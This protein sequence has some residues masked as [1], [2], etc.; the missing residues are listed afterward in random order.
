MR[1]LPAL[2][3]GRESNT[4]LAMGHAVGVARDAELGAE[5]GLLVTHA[6]TI[7]APIKVDLLGMQY[8]ATTR[9]ASEEFVHNAQPALARGLPG[10]YLH[11]HLVD[12]QST[13]FAK[14]PEATRA[15]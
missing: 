4:V 10:V 5:F 2:A 8:H 7:V 12:D 6:A 11:R 3:T 15:D 9:G 13:A 1:T 14:G